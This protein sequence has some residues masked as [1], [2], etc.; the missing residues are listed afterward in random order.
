LDELL[1]LEFELEFKELF[2]EEFE[3]ELELEFEELLELELVATRSGACAGS[4]FTAGTRSIT[5]SP[6]RARA[7]AA[8]SVAKATPAS[9]DSVIDFMVMTV[10]I[11]MR[12]SQCA[13]RSHNG[14]VAEAIPSNAPLWIFFSSID[15]RRSNSF[16]SHRTG[17]RSAESA[18][19]KLAVVEVGNAA[20]SCSLMRISVTGRS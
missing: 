4:A 15:D 2:T 11:V 3:L 20:G 10:S 12:P 9:V 14:K 7:P 16:R 1:E 17:R 13:G 18:I 6:G 19:W 5:S 8:P